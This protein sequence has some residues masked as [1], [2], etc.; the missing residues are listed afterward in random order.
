M[1]LFLVSSS[2]RDSLRNLNISDLIKVKA[3]QNANVLNTYLFAIRIK[4]VKIDRKAIEKKVA[5]QTT[6]SAV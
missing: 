4:I 6:C 2:L 3:Y 1:K 5:L